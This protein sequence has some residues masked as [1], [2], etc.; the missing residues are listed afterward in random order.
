MRP[1]GIQG[2]DSGIGAAASAGR[3]RDGCPDR[4]EGPVCAPRRQRRWARQT[5]PPALPGLGNKATA[6]SVG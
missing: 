3:P 4:N 1:D 2:L 5:P 6:A